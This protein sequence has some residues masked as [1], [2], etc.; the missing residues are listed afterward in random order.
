M[1]LHQLALLP[2][3]LRISNLAAYHSFQLGAT[4]LAAGLVSVKE[5]PPE[6]GPDEVLVQVERFS[7]NF[8]DRAVAV[9]T[10]RELNRR[11]KAQ[12]WPFGSEFQGRVVL[13]GRDVA[14]LHVGQEVMGRNDFVADGSGPQ[15]VSTNT[16]SR[17]FLKF[18]EHRVV[19]L[20]QGMPAVEASAF[21][22]AAQTGASL[23]RRTGLEKGGRLLITGGNSHTSRFAI[24]I[25]LARGLSV[26]VTS[27]GGNRWEH[28]SDQVEWISMS[29]LEM[30]AERGSAMRF[31]AV[32]D[33][34]IDV[35]APVAMPFLREYSPYVT[36]GFAGQV[37][38]GGEAP[39][40]AGVLIPAMLRNARIDVNAIGMAYDLE[41]AIDLWR[42]GVLQ[43]PPIEE[44]SSCSVGGFLDSAF[45]LADSSGRPV[46]AY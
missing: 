23:V 2:S 37:P 35:Y 21:S 41:N 22:L 17:R 13:T 5:S 19:A 1:S 3:G 15:G 12:W 10:T 30:A 36:C 43:I 6:P 26:T 45:G 40:L 42:M 4:T 39:T 44:F 38:G 18:P 14:S 20:P 46:F 11:G 7:L 32:I 28:L 24:Q 27:R 25:A 34:F 29:E 33:P 9:N 31:D 16:A 8:R